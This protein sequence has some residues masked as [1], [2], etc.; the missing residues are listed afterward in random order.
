MDI[1]AQRAFKLLDQPDT[2]IL[3]SIEKPLPDGADFRCQYK[4][5][6][7]ER[8]QHGYGMGVDAVQALLS[9]L[10]NASVDINFS[11]YARDKKLVWLEP[12]KGFGLPAP[13]GQV[14]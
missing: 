9:A 5:N 7:P 2:E 1:V 14:E 6:W 11:T 12:E 8:T 4:I 13:G 3:L 10:Q